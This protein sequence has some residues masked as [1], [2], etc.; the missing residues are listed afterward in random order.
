MNPLGIRADP[1]HRTVLE[2]RI[3][4]S[5][6]L[7]GWNF[8]LRAGERA[9]A[10]PEAVAAL[11]RCV[12]RGLPFAQGVGGERRFDPPEVVNFIKS[13]SLDG[14]D[15][16]WEDRIVAT[17]RRL[18]ADHHGESAKVSVPPAPKALG[19]RAF[20]V[21]LVRE[22]NP[23]GWAVGG[24]VR[25]RLPLPLEDEGLRD[26]IVVPDLASDIG[27]QITIA[28]GRLDVRLPVPREGTL[29]LG[30]H[31]SF[32]AYPTFPVAHAAPLAPAEIELYTRTNE[33]VASISPRIRTLAEGLAGGLKDPWQVV[34]R[35]WNYLLDRWKLGMVRYNELD[36]RHPADTLL[37]TQ[38]YDCQL[39]SGML[40]ALCRASGIPARIVSGYLLYPTAPVYHYW[41]EVA[42]EGR[43][44]VPVD[45][46]CA[47]LSSM[48]RDRAWRDYFLGQLDYRMKTQCLPR[49]FT[50]NPS[51]R[52]P[53]A[54]HILS[55]PEPAGVE[56]GYYACDSG[57]LIY[58][59][60]VGVERG[61]ATPVSDELPP[62][63]VS[64]MNAGPL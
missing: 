12:E 32:T 17:G 18:V 31:L 61:P 43:G 52:F 44:W 38:W 35:F 10:L 39:G 53:P 30:A 37:D 58:A 8:E 23:A 11:N 27:A 24:R 50:G 56:I 33:G 28:P 40:V 47:D 54:W 60:R 55:R 42:I 46:I 3:V 34:L 19:P 20:H 57:E 16:F 21:T 26:L 25:V 6:L 1:R 9:R 15:S 13:M 4:E 59:D 7:A 36:A 49:L 51:V 29:T 2:S 63:A 14:R 41:A 62:D 22:F 48:G 5:L 45:S 64:R